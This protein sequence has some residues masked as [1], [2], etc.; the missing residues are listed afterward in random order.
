MPAGIG[1][2]ARPAPEPEPQAASAADAMDVAD[3]FGSFGVSFE[4]VKEER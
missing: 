4:D 1:G 3:I 2:N